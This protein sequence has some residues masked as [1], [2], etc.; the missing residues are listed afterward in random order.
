M[1]PVRIKP[2]RFL[3]QV[4]ATVPQIPEM[5]EAPMSRLRTEPFRPWV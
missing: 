5:A 2:H 3:I 1:K 4:K